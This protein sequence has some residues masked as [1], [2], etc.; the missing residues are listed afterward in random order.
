MRPLL[1][2]IAVVC[3]TQNVQAQG[4]SL[5]ITFN[6]GSKVEFSMADNPAVTMANDLLSV[7]AGTSQLDYEL[8]RVKQFTFGT[9]TGIREV[10]GLRVKTDRI[11]VYTLNGKAVKIPVAQGEFNLS[12][13]A[14]GIYIINI[15]GNTFKYMKP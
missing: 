14:S 5:F 4:K 8:W 1:L 11:A 10:N 6:D 3:W 13:L 2:L 7:V 15:N 9:S 12:G